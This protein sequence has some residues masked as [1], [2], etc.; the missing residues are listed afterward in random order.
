MIPVQPQRL[1][2]V[3]Q[4]AFNATANHKDARRWQQAIV[5]ARQIIESNPYVELTPAGLLLLSDSGQLY[6]GITD[7]FCP[8][9][10]FNQ[11]Q[12][13]KHRALY[14]LLTRY[15]ERSH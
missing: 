6:E 2:E 7:R 4:A 10:A 14:R 9:R 12:P 3:T 11:G 15:A 1:E 8:C 5:R 13:C